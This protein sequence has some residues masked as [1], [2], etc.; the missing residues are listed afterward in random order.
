MSSGEKQKKEF[1]QPDQEKGTDNSGETH[2]ENEDAHKENGEHKEG[3]GE[4]HGE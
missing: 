4:H 2:T 1:K 3:E